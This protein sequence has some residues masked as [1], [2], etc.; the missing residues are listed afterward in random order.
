MRNMSIEELAR[1]LVKFSSPISDE[2][3]DDELVDECIIFL[4]AE[5][6]IQDIK[7]KE[8]KDNGWHI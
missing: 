6:E 5:Y 1:F 8:N 7:I 2:D 4:N 3:I